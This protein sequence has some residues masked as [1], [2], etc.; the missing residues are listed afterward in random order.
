MCLNC[1]LTGH[2]FRECLHLS[3]SA[4]LST[5]TDKKWKCLKWFKAQTLSNQ[6]SRNFNNQPWGE[7]KAGSNMASPDGVVQKQSFVK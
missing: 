2:I 4:S 1:G 3:P 5:N 7:G 6:R